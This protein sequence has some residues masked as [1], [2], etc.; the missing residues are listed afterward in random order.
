M[1]PLTSLTPS[2]T[3]EA[4]AALSLDNVAYHPKYT[5]A[6]D[7]VVLVSSDKVAF[8]IEDFYLKAAR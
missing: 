8:R 3:D 7:G 4:V 1:T 2:I 5:Q 6:A